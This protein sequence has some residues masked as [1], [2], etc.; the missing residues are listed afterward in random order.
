MVFLH[1]SVLMIRLDWI[2][3]LS[4]VWVLTFDCY[5]MGSLLMR[6]RRNRSEI[7]METIYLVYLLITILLGVIFR[8]FQGF[9]RAVVIWMFGLGVDYQFLKA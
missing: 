2:R 5:E 6:M 4:D 1:D 7:G 3:S 9:G 8:K